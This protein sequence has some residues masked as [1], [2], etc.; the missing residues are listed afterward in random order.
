[1][2]DK[3]TIPKEKIPT[4]GKRHFLIIA[5]QSLVLFN[6][7]HQFFAIDDRCPHQGASLYC[8][9]LKEHILQCPAHGL[10]FDLKTGYMLK[11]SQ[12]KLKTYPVI[13][14]GEQIVIVL[15]AEDVV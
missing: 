11:S 2:S 12:C 13:Q 14:Q 7:N 8:A 4:P 6:V 5:G 15:D 1:M 9:R 3:F 10:N